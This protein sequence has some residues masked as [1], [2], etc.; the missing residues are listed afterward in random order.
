MEPIQDDIETVR[1]RLRMD[2]EHWHRVHD[3]GASEHVTALAAL[4]SLEAQVESLREA[5]TK[6]SASCDECDAERDKWKQAYIEATV[7]VQSFE[8]ERDQL[9]ES[10]AEWEEAY[11]YLTA[12]RDRLIQEN[13]R[14]KRNESIFIGALLLMND[15][16]L[17][18]PNR[19][20]VAS[21]GTFE[22]FEDIVT[23]EV[24]FRGGP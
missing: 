9:R 7:W 17:R 11:L 8:A 2:A 13:Q 21:E 4:A 10:V 20:L 14:I 24:V 23:D 12:E 6:V 22:R 19:L 1:A 16:E 15:G 5:V 3:W 18:I